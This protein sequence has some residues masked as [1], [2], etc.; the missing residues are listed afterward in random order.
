MKFKS[1]LTEILNEAYTSYDEKQ[2]YIKSQTLLGHRIVNTFSNEIDHWYEKMVGFILD[3]GFMLVVKGINSH[4]DDTGKYIMGSSGSIIYDHEN[5]LDYDDDARKENDINPYGIDTAEEFEAAKANAIFPNRKELAKFVKLMKDQVKFKGGFDN[6]ITGEDT[7]AIEPKQVNL[8]RYNDFSFNY[9]YDVYK[10][11]KSDIKNE[12]YGN[13]ISIWFT[14]EGDIW[15]KKTISLMISY[16]LNNMG[17]LVGKPN[18]NISQTVG[19][20]SRL[21]DI[22]TNVLDG[23]VKDIL[24]QLK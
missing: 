15:H 17:K 6:M 13:F 7:F 9:L 16:S 21:E 12:R 4:N 19:A 11:E 3:N 24:K 5:W 18:I 14:T 10:Y 8:E 2:A 20:F 1:I 22:K 23:L